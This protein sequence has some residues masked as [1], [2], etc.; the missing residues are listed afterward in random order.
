VHLQRLKTPPSKF[1][2]TSK[3]SNQPLCSS[4][5]QLDSCAPPKL[6]ISPCTSPTLQRLS[7]SPPTNFAPKLYTC[8]SHEWA[9][10]L[11]KFTTSREMV[12]QANGT[13]KECQT[14]VGVRCLPSFEGLY[15]YYHLV[16]LV[17]LLSGF[18]SNY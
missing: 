1:F 12:A 18:S 15:L 14:M 11:L 3:A 10:N 16:A 13:H 17:H 9:H 4:K 8:N 5:L 6:Q 7:R 2:S